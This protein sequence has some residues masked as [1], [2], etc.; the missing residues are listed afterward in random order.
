M[1]LIER[2]VPAFYALFSM[3]LFWFSSRQPLPKSW[4]YAA[5]A[6]VALIVFLWEVSRTWG[7]R[8]QMAPE[9]LQVRR[10]F[11]WNVIPWAQIRAVEVRS[12]RSRGS[13]REAVTLT[14]A[15][16]ATLRLGVFGYLGARALRDRIRE[17]IAQR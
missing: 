5:C 3:W 11:R 1:P 15:S 10:Y 8:L 4:F 2:V 14:L 7:W 13:V 12:V 9:E 16:N 6:S 17:E